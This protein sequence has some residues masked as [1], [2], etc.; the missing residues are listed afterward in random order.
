M[1]KI[2]VLALILS[3]FLIQAADPYGKS[4]VTF[5][6][7]TTQQLHKLHETLTNIQKRNDTR[8]IYNLD[9]F[10]SKSNKSADEQILEHNFVRP[11][12][13]QYQEVIHQEPSYPE[14]EDTDDRISKEDYVENFKVLTDEELDLLLR[15]KD[16]YQNNYQK[17]N[18]TSEELTPPAT[19]G[20]P[21]GTIK[22]SLTRRD[23]QGVAP[24]DPEEHIGEILPPDFKF[25]V[26]TKETALPNRRSY[27]YNPRSVV[28]FPV[29]PSGEDFRSY[30]YPKRLRAPYLR[31]EQT[32]F[33]PSARFQTVWGTSRRPRVIFPSDLVQFREPINSGTAPA[34][35]PDWLAPD[36]ALQDLEGADNRD[37]GEC[38][39]KLFACTSCHSRL[40]KKL[41]SCVSQ[42][43]VSSL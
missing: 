22:T 27:V 16:K 43:T 41:K 20:Q 40:V 37:R 12:L 23:D 8:K 2:R 42:H 18:S 13:T 31:A 9:D 26:S 17:E 4:H 11:L 36:N 10:L 19:N 15:D 7:S 14:V 29:E 25:D 28:S 24:G 34:D 39:C 35:E 1:N 30:R 6:P 38:L 33:D 5:T 3:I 32:Y 21:Y